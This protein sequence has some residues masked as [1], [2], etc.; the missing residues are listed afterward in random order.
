MKPYYSE[1]GITIYHG[2]AREILPQ[3]ERADLIMT[4]PPYL[5]EFIPVYGS[6][7]ENA[8]RLLKPGGFCYAYLGAQF[9]PQVMAEMA[10][11]LDW[12]W[13]FNIRHIGN[14][15]RMWNKRLMVSSKPCFVFTNGKVHQ[16]D[17]AW[18]ATDHD[19]E[20]GGDKAFHEWGQSIGFFLKHIELRTKP[21]D[22]VLDPFLGGGT[23]LRA[24]KDLHRKAIGIELDEESCEI[25]ARR[26]S[27]E[28]F[29][30]G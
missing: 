14:H 9:A 29:Q 8:K 23:T 21:G 12:F 6:L 22:T 18:C 24:A 26:L 25:A 27:Q 11:H 2:D 3:I 7:A 13:I 17:L 1:A 28:V 30:F 10:P 19:S 20:R 15:P 5:E 16:D 4:D